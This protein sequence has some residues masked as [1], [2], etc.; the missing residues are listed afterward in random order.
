MPHRTLAI[1]MAMAFWA[2]SAAFLWG[3]TYL[4]PDY[5]TATPSTGSVVT[6]SLAQ[7]PSTVDAP[8]MGR[9]RG[10]TIVDVPVDLKDV[11]ELGGEPKSI[12]TF[13]TLEKQQQTVARMSSACTV[14]VQIGRSQGCGVIVTSSGYVLTAAHVA[15]RPGKFAQI[16]LSDGRVVRGRTLGMNRYVDAGLMKIEAGQNQGRPWPHASLGKSREVIEGAWC[17]AMGH[18]GGFDIGRPPVPRIG[19]VLHVSPAAIETDCALIGGDS[20]G[21]LFDLSG[22]LIAIHSR[23]GNDLSENLHVPIDHYD[24]HWARMQKGEAY[25]FLAGFKPILGVKGTGDGFGAVIDII[26]EDGPAE[27]AG[28]KPNDRIEKFGDFEVKTFDDLKSAVSDTMPG[29]R[30][31]IRFSR[32]GQTIETLVEI[33]R[34]DD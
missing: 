27:K 28:L 9:S 30:V 16:T 34:D 22:R 25:G 3:Q 8:S 14:S 4:P 21:P 19:R 24:L 5:Q 26:V 18:P 2:T 12:E 10:Q 1:V 11:F 17:V 29:E 20:G 33:G 13:L 6:N 15:M 31:I 7:S 32:K 23:I